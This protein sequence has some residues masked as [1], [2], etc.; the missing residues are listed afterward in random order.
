MPYT[1]YLKQFV[2]FSIEKLHQHPTFETFKENLVTE[3]RTIINGASAQNVPIELHKLEHYL[4]TEIRYQLMQYRKRY[5]T[6]QVK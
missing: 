2:S 6:L 5:V 1:S 3:A 4:Q